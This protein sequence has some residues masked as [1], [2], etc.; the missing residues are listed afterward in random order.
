MGDTQPN[1]LLKVL[2]RGDA[3]RIFLQGL[4]RSIRLARRRLAKPSARM[5]QRLLLDFHQIKGAAGFFGFIEIRD[6]A[7]AI[8]R[9][10]AAAGTDRAHELRAL[11]EAIAARAAELP[12][13]E[14]PRGLPE[15]PG[16][17]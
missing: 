16:A 6:A 5:Q 7:A 2:L 9:I 8:E 15:R 11:V 17:L 4:L 3:Y 1:E 14:G 13:P 12:T 10:C